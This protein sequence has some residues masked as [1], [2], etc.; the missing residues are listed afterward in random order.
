MEP[1]QRHLTW[2]SQLQY[3]AG[4]VSPQQALDAG[5]TTKAIEWRLHTGT[6]RRLYRGVYATFTGNWPDVTEYCCRNAAEIAEVLRSQ[7][8][9]GTLRRCGPGCTAAEPQDRDRAGRQ[10]RASGRSGLA[11]GAG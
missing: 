9:T 3:Q 10:E 1:D 8:W 2:L 4:V 5:L 11:A 7:G 6:W